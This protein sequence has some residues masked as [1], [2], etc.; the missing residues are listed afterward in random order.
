M[1]NSK[2][3]L[4]VGIAISALFIYLALRPVK[5]AEVWNAIVSFKWIWAVPFLAATW[6]S[7]YIRAI[8]WHYLV[9][10]AR[11]LSPN[12]LFSPMMIGFAMNSILPA[13]AGE[14]ARAYVL[15]KKENVPFTS[16]FATVVVERIFD[17]LTLL[18]MLA[19][20]FSTLRFETGV[21]Y[22]YST[23]SVITP[24]QVILWVSMAAGLLLVLGLGIALLLRGRVRARLMQHMDHRAKKRGAASVGL[25]VLRL[26]ERIG[27]PA[28]LDGLWI[29]LVVIAAVALVWVR[30]PRFGPQDVIHLGRD[31]VID[32]PMLRKFSGQI[33]VGSVIMLLG[34]L[35]LIWPTGRAFILKLN[36]KLPYAPRRLRAKLGEMV[37]TFS[38]G[39]S[40]L[41]DI[42]TSAIVLVLSVMVWVLVGWSMQLAACGFEGMRMNVL[43][44]IA[45]T[46]IICIAILIP[47]APGYWGLMEIGTVFGMAILGLESNYGRALGYSLIC[48]SLQYFPIVFVGLYYLWKEKISLSEISGKQSSE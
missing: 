21:Q 35:T 10:P 7:L 4:I 43:E 45:V 23:K 29:L 42:R 3:Q 6:L 48:H 2:I 9:R 38:Q 33:A 30:S 14:F 17:M 16:A 15:G 36:E 11:F 47:A 27:P 31:Y 34:S 40:S 13:R 39:L 46:V 8:R 5:P 41:G 28:W 25:R 22:S 24:H 26:I 18:L 44:G 1:K 32:G 12:R 19:L 37:T 20:V